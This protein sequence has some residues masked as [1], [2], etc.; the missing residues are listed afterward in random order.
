MRTKSGF[1]RAPTWPLLQRLRRRD[2]AAGVG[3]GVKRRAGAARLLQ[4][5]GEPGKAAPRG[6]DASVSLLGSRSRRPR[7]QRQ[8]RDSSDPARPGELSSLPPSVRHGVVAVRDAAAAQAPGSAQ[9]LGDQAPA[10]I[11]SRA[12]GSAQ[13]PWATRAQIIITPLQ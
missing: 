5:M 13:G 12:S 11:H 8:L 6:R 1:C 3:T 9:C 7:F 4:E 10:A 2:A